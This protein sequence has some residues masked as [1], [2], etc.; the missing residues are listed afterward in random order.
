MIS[1]LPEPLLPALLLGTDPCL[2]PWRTSTSFLMLIVH[3]TYCDCLLV[4][5]C[6]EAEQP[7][8]LP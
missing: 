4:R 6:A 1:L 2:F 8:F 3:L 7:E 5:M